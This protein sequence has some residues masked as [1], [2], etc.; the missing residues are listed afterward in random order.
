MASNN[1]YKI[2]TQL[3][4][5]SGVLFHAPS[6]GHADGLRGSRKCIIHNDICWDCVFDCLTDAAAVT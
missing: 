4:C 3:L 2:M 5:V 6:R 1:C